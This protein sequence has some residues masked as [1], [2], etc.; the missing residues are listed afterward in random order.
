MCLS[1]DESNRFSLYGGVYDSFIKHL[2]RLQQHVF[3][4]SCDPSIIRRMS[5][6]KFRKEGD[7]LSFSFHNKFCGH[8]SSDLNSIREFL[9]TPLWLFIE[10]DDTK[11][12]VTIEEIPLSLNIDQLEYKFLY[13]I[14]HVSETDP[15]Q[16]HFQSVFLYEN[17]FFLVDDLKKIGKNVPLVKLSWMFYYLA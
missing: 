3:R 10:I 4:C 16:N 12:A 15:D 1:P 8:C 11:G 2:I 14:F 5:D 7:S 17:D 9:S 13:S 6:L